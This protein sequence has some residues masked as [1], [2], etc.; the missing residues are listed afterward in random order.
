MSATKHLYPVYYFGKSFFQVLLDFIY[1]PTCIQCNQRLNHPGFV[2]PRC[3]E[4]IL[5]LMKPTFQ[6][7]RDDFHHIEGEIFFDEVVTF[8]DYTPEIE[9]LI[10]QVKYQRK[11]KLGLFLGQHLGKAFVPACGD[12]DKSVIIPVPLHKARHRE[13]GYNQSE[14]LCRGIS[15]CVKAPIYYDGLIRNRHTLTQT[16]LSAKERQKNVKDAFETNPSCHIQRKDIVLVDDVITTGATVNNC[17]AC[18]KKAGARK[19]IGIA[20]AR[21]QLD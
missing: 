9:Q 16:R 1:P 18:L 6:K 3:Q 17:A 15:N 2:C 12:G 20:L 11:K 14:I 5:G 19:V 10:F 21:P 4:T 13:R 8:W 7:G